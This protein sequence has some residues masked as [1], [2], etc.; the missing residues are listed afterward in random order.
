MGP[1]EK[2][3]QYKKLMTKSYFEWKNMFQVNIALKN[4]KLYI[5]K[6]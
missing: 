2:T 5:A 1:E 6:K 3:M 4:F